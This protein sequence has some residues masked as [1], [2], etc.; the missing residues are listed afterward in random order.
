MYPTDGPRSSEA[1]HAS[2]LV[3]RDD[4]EEKRGE[5]DGFFFTSLE[6]R[7]C[8][9]LL[10]LCFKRTKKKY[11]SGDSDN[12]IDSIHKVDVTVKALAL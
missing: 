11:T 9:R 7:W 3:I 8:L 1:P 6:R 4:Q 5:T 2:F 12:Y 10:L